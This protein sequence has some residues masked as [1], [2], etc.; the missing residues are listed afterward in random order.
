MRTLFVRG[1]KKIEAPRSSRVGIEVKMSS[2]PKLIGDYEKKFVDGVMDTYYMLCDLEDVSS[3]EQFWKL[4]SAIEASYN[5]CE[6]AKKNYFELLTKDGGTAEGCSLLYEIHEGMYC[7][8]EKI[9]EI[10]SFLTATRLVK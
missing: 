1:I 7:L 4:F 3:D 6:T 10:E 9:N 2:I 8:D 5:E